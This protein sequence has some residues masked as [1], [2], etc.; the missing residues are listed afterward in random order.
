MKSN[1]EHMQHRTNGDKRPDEILAEIDRTRDEMDR[2]LSAIEQRLTPGQLVDQGIDYL[3]HSGAAEFVQNLGGTAKQNPLPIALT[4]IGIGWLMAL[5]REPAQQNY[6]ATSSSSLR[7]G[8]G[9]MRDKASGALH[10]ASDSLSSARDRVSGSMSSMRG[11]ASESMSSMR[12]RA[13]QMTESARY[14]WDRARGGVDYLVREQPLALGAIGLAVGAILAAMAPKTQKEEELM[15]E[16]S[17]NLMDKAKATGSQQ[18]EKA[19]ETVK[20]VAERAGGEGKQEPQGQTS[21][22]RA[23]STQTQ[24]KPNASTGGASSTTTQTQAKPNVQPRTTPQTQHPGPTAT[25]PD[26]KGGW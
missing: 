8:M 7:E 10:S 1:G 23:S 11:R 4:A 13:G 14:R 6:G 18:L 20:Q 5:G 19:Q 9:S 16:A 17:R 2:T 22:Q 25:G 3:R 15:G 21:T 12:D 24:A 26:K